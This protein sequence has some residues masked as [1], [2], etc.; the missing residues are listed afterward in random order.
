M[1]KNSID[2][3]VL[4]KKELMDVSLSNSLADD[5]SDL[6]RRKISIIDVSR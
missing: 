2:V 3:S 4:F 1:Q 6:F 5:K